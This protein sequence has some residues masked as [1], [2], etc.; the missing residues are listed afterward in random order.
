VNPV[1]VHDQVAAWAAGKISGM[2]RAYKLC[3]IL[4]EF[5]AAEDDPPLCID[6]LTVLTAISDPL[7]LDEVPVLEFAQ[8]ARSRPVARMDKDTAFG[9]FIFLNYKYEVRTL[10]SAYCW[11]GFKTI[12]GT[13]VSE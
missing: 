5:N 1:P 11:R 12:A 2:R 7:V 6:P 3:F 4:G 9:F 13:S 10:E 8:P